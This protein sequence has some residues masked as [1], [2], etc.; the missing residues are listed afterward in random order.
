MMMFFLIDY[1]PFGGVF[2]IIW[3][4]DS[5]DRDLFQASI[6]YS[7]NFL[8]IALLIFANKQDLPSATVEEL[9]EIFQ[10]N[11]LNSSRGYFQLGCHG[12]SLKDG[13]V[14]DPEAFI[15]DAQHIKESRTKSVNNSYINII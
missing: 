15:P 2:T 12:E 6:Y 14:D 10:L 7:K 5:A 9:T 1:T 13:I 11:C 3:V 4:Q 8:R